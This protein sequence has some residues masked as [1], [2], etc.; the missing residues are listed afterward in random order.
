[1]PRR[2]PSQEQ[3]RYVDA[4]DQ[5]HEANSAQDHEQRW[6][7]LAGELFLHG[8]QD[9]TPILFPPWIERLQACR[10]RSHFGACRFDRHAGLQSRDRA[11][12]LVTA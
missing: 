10:Q 11:Q 3:I 6:L 8:H 4:A 9:E 2:R 1:L 12:S 7:H 5:Q